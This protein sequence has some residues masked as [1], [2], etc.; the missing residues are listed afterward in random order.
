[1]ASIKSDV[2]VDM[3]PR[4]LFKTG[5]TLLGSGSNSRALQTF[6]KALDQDESNATYLAH[7]AWAM[8]LVDN[9]DVGKATKLLKDAVKL[10]Q[11]SDLEWPTLFLGHL[12]MAEGNPNG[13]VENYRKALTANPGNIEA[14]RRLRLH[15]MR[16]K[17]TGSFLDKL[18]SKSKKKKG[19]SN[20]STNK[21]R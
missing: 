10:A 9:G 2:G 1:M 16:N 7:Y 5:T 15:D 8:Y 3:D 11:G 12:Y 4:Q 17:G 20:K 21:K 19:S 6:K 13:G 18:F 14:K